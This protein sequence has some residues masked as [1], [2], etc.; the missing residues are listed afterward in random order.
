M[1]RREFCTDFNCGYDFSSPQEA[2][3]PTPLPTPQA[4]PP[5]TPPSEKELPQV[6]TPDSSP[7]PP[8]MSGDVREREKIKETGIENN[9]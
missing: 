6:R 8:E 2:P 7:S 9:N 3:V 5:P 1:G 4:T